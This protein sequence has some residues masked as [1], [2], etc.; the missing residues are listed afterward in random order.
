MR[1]RPTTESAIALLEE[2]YP[3]KFDYSKFQYTRAA[4][5]V[6]LICKDCGLEFQTIYN[7]LRNGKSKDEIEEIIKA[8]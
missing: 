4:D 6:S 7:T 3:N 1:K 5:K 2:K 8:L